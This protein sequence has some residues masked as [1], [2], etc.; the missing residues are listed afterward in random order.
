METSEKIEIA[1]EMR[2]RAAAALTTVVRW[3][4]ST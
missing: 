4:T 2:R 3:Q 1:Q